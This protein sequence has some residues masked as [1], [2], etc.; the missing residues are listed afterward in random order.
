METTTPQRNQKGKVS[1]T[2]LESGLSR[3][4]ELPQIYAI[5]ILESEPSLNI[6]KNLTPTVTEEVRRIIN[7][8]YLK[9]K[10]ID[11]QPYDYEMDIH[12][13]SDVPFHHP[14][15]R[16]SYMEKLDVQKKI[17]EMIEEGIISPSDSPYASAIVLVKKKDGSTRMCVDYRAL[18]KLTV[19]DN[20]PLPLIDDCVDYMKGKSFF[21]L[22]DLKSGF[23]Q[24]RVSERSRKYTS[25][26]TPNTGECHLDS[27]T[28]PPYSRDS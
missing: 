14:P 19:R 24:V 10:N 28:H 1:L 12:L 4:F 20:Y 22:L 5:D 27:G 26:V 25:F 17:C 18:N 2:L 15:R 9:P 13:T 21:T 23:H 3:E 6:G 7:D 8:N 11:V 16:L